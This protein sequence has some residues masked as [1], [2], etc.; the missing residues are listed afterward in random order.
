MAARS[1]SGRCMGI[2]D[3]FRKRTPILDPQTEGELSSYEDKLGNC[4][5]CNRS[6]HIRVYD[7]LVRPSIP[8][9]TPSC[10]RGWSTALA[11]NA[12]K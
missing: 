2:F 8:M 6:F 10:S 9:L 12:A 3:L 5:V 1:I 4:P 11:A 7:I